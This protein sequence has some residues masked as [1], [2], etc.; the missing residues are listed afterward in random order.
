MPIHSELPSAIGDVVTVVGVD[1]SSARVSLYGGHVVS[2]QTA[3]GCERLFVSH[4]A[5][6]EGGAAIR[7]GIPVCFPQF[8]ALGSLPKH[9]FARTARWTQMGPSTFSLSVDVGAWAGW[10]YA[11]SLV[12]EVLLG[13]AT[14]TT[15]LRVSNDGDEA[16]S[17]TGALHT[18][19]ACHDVTG[20]SVHGLDGCN[21]H[22]SGQVAGPIT[23]GDG[24]AD[25]DVSV[26]RAPGAVTVS[27]IT[28]SGMTAP[29]APSESM[30]CAQSGFGDVVVWNVG[31]TLGAAMS[32]LGADQWRNYVCVEAA[33]VG[34]AVVVEPGASWVGSQTLM[35]LSTHP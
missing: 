23:F 16:F 20:V 1:G 9:G 26:L 18:Y 35:V 8:A 17:F 24:V 10:P 28:V 21:I 2:W 15:M 27:G 30:V 13:P 11:C 33:V 5:T 3:D 6:I 7:G 22:G 12:L 31:A 29:G 25:V 14:L 4:R 34:E 32:D 19:L